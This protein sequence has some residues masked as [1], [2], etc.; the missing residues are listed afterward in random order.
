M[1]Q[2]NKH[3]IFFLWC[4]S[5]LKLVLILPV[6]TASAERCFSAMDV[7]KKKLGNKMSDL[8]MS[9]CLICYVEKVMSSTI[10]NDEVFE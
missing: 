1:V 5:N 7:L 3:V 2:T 10:T 6:V 8:F 4:L 9:N